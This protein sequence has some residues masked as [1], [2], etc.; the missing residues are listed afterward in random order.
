V[1]KTNF[2][3][4]YHENYRHISTRI[5]P[6]NLSQ[7]PFHHKDP[8]DRILLSQAMTEGFPLLNNDTKFAAYGLNVIW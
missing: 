7:L 2:R 3:D 4:K 6:P 5:L 1:V 8:F